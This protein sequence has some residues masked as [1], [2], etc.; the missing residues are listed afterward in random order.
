MIEA[1][2]AAVADFGIEHLAGGERLVALDEFKDV[3]WLGVVAAP[4][5]IG[6]RVIDDDRHDVRV[7][8]EHLA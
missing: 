8:L 3:V 4:R 7:L 6:K 5:Y 2:A 1:E